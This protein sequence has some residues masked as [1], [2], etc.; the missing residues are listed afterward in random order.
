[1]GIL[2]ILLPKENEPELEDLPEEV[3]KNLSFHQVDTLDEVLAIALRS[4]DAKAV[5]ELLS[6]KTR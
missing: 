5:D 6:A 1:M 2:E 4:Q 3:R